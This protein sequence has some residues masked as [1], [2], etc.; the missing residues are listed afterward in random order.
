MLRDAAAL[1]DEGSPNTN[2][3][4]N[5]SDSFNQY[6]DFDDD[7][8]NEMRS[9]IIR[10]SFDHDGIDEY[11]AYK[12]NQEV[13]KETALRYRHHFGLNLIR[14]FKRDGLNLRMPNS[15]K[16]EASAVNRWKIQNFLSTKPE[17]IPTST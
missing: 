3:R 12:F 5:M 15:I 7:S 1:I 2:H 10:E 17:L 16:S 14:I 4:A 9:F 13:E 11:H 8:F 6:D